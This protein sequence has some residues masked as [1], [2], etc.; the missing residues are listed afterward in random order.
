MRFIKYNEFL[1]SSLVRQFFFLLNRAESCIFY[2]YAT[3]LDGI[4]GRKF[5]LLY[6]FI[7]WLTRL[8]VPLRHRRSSLR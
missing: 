5:R 2:C 7:P 8:N 3:L 4:F 6:G 1:V